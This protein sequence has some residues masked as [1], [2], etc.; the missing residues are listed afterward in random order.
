MFSSFTSPTLLKP[1]RWS[2]LL[3]AAGTMLGCKDNG[4]S[5][6]DSS[7]PNFL[8]T[9]ATEMSFQLSHASYSSNECNEQV[10]ISDDVPQGGEFPDAA[11]PIVDDKQWKATHHFA[12]SKRYHLIGGGYM[13]LVDDPMYCESAGFLSPC[14]SGAAMI[15]LYD[16]ANKKAF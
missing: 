2:M 16:T 3:I 5:S 1:L 13:Q 6:P 4:D 8:V 12:I 7:A 14:E 9:E 10:C 11:L 15:Y